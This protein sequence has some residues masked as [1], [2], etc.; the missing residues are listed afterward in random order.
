MLPLYVVILQMC[1]H[2]H[3]VLLRSR[4]VLKTKI[5]YDVD[6][7]FSVYAESKLNDS[8]IIK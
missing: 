7:F 8:L 2:C 1:D 6:M 4:L 3:S 5:I